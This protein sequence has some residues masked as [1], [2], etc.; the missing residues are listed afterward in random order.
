MEHTATDFSFETG[1]ALLTIYGV[2]YIF[3]VIAGFL[4]WRSFQNMVKFWVKSDIAKP[5]PFTKYFISFVSGTVFNKT[6]DLLYK[7]SRNQF[8]LAIGFLFIGFVFFIYADT[9]LFKS[10]ESFFKEIPH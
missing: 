9:Y 2:F 8:S 7:S 3:I 1:M 10:I 4:L 5:M 6:T